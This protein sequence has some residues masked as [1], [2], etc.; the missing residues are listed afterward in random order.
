MNRYPIAYGDHIYVSAIIDG[1]KVLEINLTH[2]ADISVLLAEIR[3]AGRRLCGLARMFIRNHSQGWSIQRPFRFYPDF[4]S[5][6][7]PMQ[8]MERPRRQLAAP[9]RRC[10]FPWETH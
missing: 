2:I 1:R 4:P 6:G 3:Q 7:R 5:P 8:R 9:A 10:I